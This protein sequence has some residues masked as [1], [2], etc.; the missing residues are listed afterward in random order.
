MLT[1]WLPAEEGGSAVA[2]VLFGNVNPGGKLPISF[3]RS[4]GQIPVYYA[5][6]PSGGRSHWTGNYVDSSAAPLYPFGHGLSYTTFAYDHLKIDKPT[7]PQD[8]KVKIEFDL[9]NTGNRD[10]DEVVQLYIRYKP[11]NCTITRPVKE[12][13]GFTRVHVRSGE[14]NHLTFTLYAHQLAFYQ[15][16]M[17]YVVSPGTVAVMIGSSSEDLRLSGTFTI[18]GTSAQVV[19]KKVFF[20]DVTC[21]EKKKE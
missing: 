6:K 8:G 9:Q 17:S 14:S 7:I 1:A 2:D 12:L 13:K 4:V 11:V 3:P 15:E 18:S 19:T 5:H 21:E 10:G 16:N 20:S